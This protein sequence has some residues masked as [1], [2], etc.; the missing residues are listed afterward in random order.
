MVNGRTVKTEPYSIQEA[1]QKFYKAA[2]NTDLNITFSFP[3][4]I[5]KNMGSNSKED[6]QSRYGPK[7]A[8]NLFFQA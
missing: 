8:N 3:E 7:V 5:E 4:T 6:A 2:K 1:Y